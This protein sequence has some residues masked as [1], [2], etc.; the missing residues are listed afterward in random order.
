[1]AI[2]YREKDTIRC[3]RQRYPDG[4]VIPEH[5]HDYHQ[6]L[7]AK[8]GLLVVHSPLG[9]WVVPPTRAIW[10]PV[11]TTH[12]S[13]CVGDVEQRNVSI[14][15]DAVDP[16]LPSVPTAVE[17]GAL[18]RQLL[19]SAEEVT[20]PYAQDSRDGRLMRLI[21][22]ELKTVAVLPLHLPSPVDT[23]LVAI[24][25]HIAGHLDDRTTLADWAGQTGLHLK[26][27]QRLFM[28]ELGMTFGQWRQRSRLL[29]GLEQLASGV[30]VIDVALALGYDSPSAFSAMFRR[31]FGLSPSAYF[32]PSREV[33]VV[34]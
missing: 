30:S 7:Y 27:I 5:R 26:T 20:Y 11:G 10:M 14:E 8:Q 16:G 31:H 34:G 2:N 28:R 21:V 25:S 19:Q 13:R 23:R 4:T 15:V 1:M 22:D 33:S 6:L 32:R 12:S 3:Q 18:L 9:R 24:C 17:V 29:A